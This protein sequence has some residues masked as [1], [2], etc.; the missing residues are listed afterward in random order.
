MCIGF[1][2]LAI[3]YPSPISESVITWGECCKN[4]SHIALSF[5]NL[6]YQVAPFT[7]EAANKIFDSA[8]L[9]G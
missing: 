5:S 9:N 6:A 3:C 4:V 8:K 2:L 7:D 1:F